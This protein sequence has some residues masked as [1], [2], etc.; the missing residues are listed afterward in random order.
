MIN[1]IHTNIRLIEDAIKWARKYGKE[2][3]PFEILKDYRRTLKRIKNAL[4]ENCSAAAYGE[5]QVGKSYLMGSLL[6]SPEAP[7]MI[8]NGNEVYNFIDQIN[9]SGG[10]NAKIESTGVVTRFSLT[11]SKRQLTDK[12]RVRNLSVVD[13]I[14]LITDSYYNDLKINPETVMKYDEINE[15][16]E[17]LAYIWQSH[18]VVQKNITEDDVKD[19]AEYI[20]ENIGNN[21][22]NVYQSSF[23]KTIAPV[24]EYIPYHKWVDVF[25][26]L[27]NRNTEF[28]HL[29]ATL[30]TAFK[31]INFE[32]EIYVPFDAVLRDH[33]TLLK[34]DWLDHVCGKKVRNSTE[35]THTDIYN[36]KG[37][38][39]AKDFSKGN[40]SALIAELTFYLPEE[41]ATERKFLK[42]IDLLDFPGARSREKYREHEIQS[43]LPKILRRGKVAYLFNKYSRDL[44]ISSVLF[45]HHNDQKTEP[46]IGNTINTWIENNIGKTPTQRETLLADT[47]GIAPLFLIATKFNIDLERVK[48]D[49]PNNPEKLSQHWNRFDTV[50]PEIIKPNRW[51]DEWVPDHGVH[52]NTFFTNVYPLRDF[53]WSSKNGLFDGYMEGVSGETGVHI[54]NDYPAYMDNLKESFLEHPFVKKHFKNPKETW[55]SVATPNND[56]SK[57]IIENLNT[58]AGVLDHARTEKYRKQLQEIKRQLY[59]RLMVYFESDDKDEQNR[60]VKKIGGEIRRSMYL[61]VGENPELFGK[62]IDQL[63]MPSWNVRCIAYDIIVCHTDTPKDFSQLS[64]L[65]KTIGIQPKDSREEKIRK[66]CEWGCC[67]LKQLEDDFAKK[68]FS[69]EDLIRDDQEDLTTLADVVT[70]HVVEEWKEYMNSQIPKLMETLPHADEVIFMLLSLFDKLNIKQ[71]LSKKIDLY[72]KRL[73]EEQ[74]INAIADFASL[75]LNNFIGNI[76]RNYLTDKDLKIVREKAEACQLS[77]DLSE[78]ACS[79]KH[80][81]QDL[82]ATLCAFEDSQ[83]M[84]TVNIDTLRKLPLW[85][86]FQRWENFT[87]M[88]LLLVSDIARFDPIANGELKQILDQCDALYQKA[89]VAQPN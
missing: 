83:S 12:V 54:D 43:V 55:E 75:T 15:A 77:L 27:W 50:L 11:D 84:E 14:L 72:I 6:S 45:C 71:L 56:G 16:L 34:I 30:I 17:E 53:Y 41:V 24:I 88:G 2:S 19:I 89:E 3:F 82:V 85:D 1:D 73:T 7:F 39:I 79:A 58:I 48:T 66:L 4:N 63:M 42:Q 33:G 47:K 31:D 65:R 26:L 44:K 40:L 28:S 23:C 62:A 68:G 67:E 59:D 13:L 36:A 52:E 80:E 21:A 25:S 22:S 57:V 81:P 35:V 76:G 49:S 86:N 18:T 78:E 70:K 20:R 32:T 69:V 8:R 29:F 64:F 61:N 10:N 51:F 9:P 37:E 5:S 74:A 38:L 60:K 87:L 46:S